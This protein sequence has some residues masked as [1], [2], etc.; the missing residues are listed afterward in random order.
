M[1]ISSFD[2]FDT[3]IVRKCGAPRN[4]FDVLS[5]RVFSEKVS[6]ED[7][8]EFITQRISSDD[9]STFDHLYYTFNYSHPFLLARA[10]IKQK[11]LE[12]EREMMVPVD[13]ML[14]K[15]NQCR[16]NGD[17][18]VFI[19]DMY[20]PTD[21]LKDALSEFGFFKKDDSIYISGD[22]GSKKADG[23]LFEWIKEKEHV[24]YDHWQHYGDNM[25]S[26][27]Q[28]PSELGIKTHY[29]NHQYLPFE[30]IWLDNSNDITFHTGG[31]MA[32]IGRSLLLS[33][34]YNEHNAFALDI[35]APL[36]STFAM[37]IMSDASARG[38]KR[39]YFCSR[40]C[41]ALFHVAQKLTRIN[42]SVEPIYFHTSRKALYNT[43]KEELI[44]YLAHIGMACNDGQVGI[45]DIRTSGNSLKYLNEL[46]AD[47][48]FHPVYGY[49]LEMFCT[50]TYMDVFPYYCE[51][52]KL[53][54]TMFANHH[55]ILEKFL[56]LSPEGETVGYKNNVPIIEPRKEN[57]DYHV[58]N[59]D[60]LTTV[61]LSILS[62]YSD[63][64]VDTELYR[65]CDEVFCSFV[66]PTI[67]HFFKAP[68]KKYLLS[69]RNLLVQREDG[70]YLPYV[71]EIP[72]GFSFKI[73]QIAQDSKVRIVRRLMKLIMRVSHIKPLP[74][75]KWWPEGTEAYNNSSNSSFYE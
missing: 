59:I 65:Y 71:D 46:F 57:E 2:I 5:Y 58:C 8:I 39:L 53:Y 16:E 56:S 1:T 10:E 63:F 54:N 70:S 21:F 19:S 34:P 28:I 11:E 35:A 31:I 37:R 23:S 42:P 55:P 52:N 15:V 67:K 27:V 17:Y 43:P 68:D 69:L 24:E 25:N 66:I 75:E 44:S 73:A 64:F 50:D 45:V 32:G 29:V 20:L 40:D 26:D 36:M 13:E 60:S 47:H 49:Y 7:R 51:V 12:C 61:N 30:Q 33:L 18:I 3:C 6:E 9:T 41:Y 14:Q 38:I 48:G 62:K 72:S 22:C 74:K 4:L